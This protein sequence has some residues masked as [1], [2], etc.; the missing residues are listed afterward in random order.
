M[1]YIANKFECVVKHFPI[2]DEFDYVQ[3]ST[4][5]SEETWKEISEGAD[6]PVSTGKNKILVQALDI[7]GSMYGQ[8]M[9]ALKVGAQLI[10]DKY[11][12]AEEKPF[13]KF[14]TILHDH[15][16]EAFESANHEEYKHRIG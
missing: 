14:I 5:V 3:Y 11:F 16:I 4:T 15:N 1:S 9:Q 2:D 13:D 8:P 6:G 7:S 10:G 12:G